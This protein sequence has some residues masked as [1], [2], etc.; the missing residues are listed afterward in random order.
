MSII[1]RPNNWPGVKPRLQDRVAVALPSV[2]ESISTDQDVP[3]THV[4]LNSENTACEAPP[5]NSAVDVT[6]RTIDTDQAPRK[7]VTIY[8]TALLALAEA[9][10]VDETKD[11]LD[12][13]IALGE[14]AKHAKDPELL[15]YATSIRLCAERR[16]GEILA[17]MAEKGER[18][19]GKGRNPCLKSQAATP[20]LAD[21]GITKSQS[22]RWQRLAELTPEEFEA[23]LDQRKNKVLSI[24]ERSPKSI[25]ARAGVRDDERSR[26]KRVRKAVA[27]LAAAGSSQVVVDALVSSGQTVELVNLKRAITF[28]S[29]LAS[30]LEAVEGTSPPS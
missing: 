12:K 16:A 7:S 22:S 9:N 27:I 13:A 10:H 17:E 4:D 1:S 8:N 15:K 5:S 25:G 30:A 21:L 14:Y 23:M 3:K 6:N 28:L 26:A 2:G 18:D 29:E 20:K 11:I 19:N 24:F